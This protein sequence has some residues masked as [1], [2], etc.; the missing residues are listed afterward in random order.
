MSPALEF[1][2]RHNV[3]F[4]TPHVA[5]RAVFGSAHV[6]LDDIDIVKCLA[7]VGNLGR[8]RSS[9]AG[10]VEVDVVAG[11]IE[12]MRCSLTE[13]IAK[14]NVIDFYLSELTTNEVRT[15]SS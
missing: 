11:V 5:A 15:V 3:T 6:E 8:L 10:M 1:T 9:S 12:K 7:L 2:V 4:M 13:L 14:P